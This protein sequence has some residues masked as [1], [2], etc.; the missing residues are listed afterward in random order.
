VLL[1]LP[2]YAA[3]STWPLNGSTESKDFVSQMMSCTSAHAKGMAGTIENG[4][5]SMSRRA[6]DSLTSHCSQ[7]VPNPSMAKMAEQFELGLRQVSKYSS[8]SNVRKLF[9]AKDRLWPEV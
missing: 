5:A 9:E 2:G 1:S 7:T 8:Y 4:V 3:L 6:E